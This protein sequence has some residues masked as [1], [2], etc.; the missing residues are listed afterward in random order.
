MLT[1]CR[2]WVKPRK[3]KNPK[4]KDLPDPLVLTWTPWPCSA[5]PAALEHGTW[6]MFLSEVVSAGGGSN[7]A[8]L[9]RP[10]RGRAAASSFWPPQ[11][12]VRF[13]TS[14]VPSVKTTLSVRACELHCCPRAHDAL[15][16]CFLPL[17]ERWRNAWS[18]LDRVGT[19][20][21]RVSECETVKTCEAHYSV[22]IIHS[23]LFVLVVY[24]LRPFCV[25]G[26]RSSCLPGPQ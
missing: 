15:L 26:R 14:A 12:T 8:H 2:L 25:T 7:R 24:V 17:K 10:V 1:C 21:G 11:E 19:H 4:H 13:H 16:H 6:T 3:I 20:V 23:T 5:G 9:R 22:V 18:A